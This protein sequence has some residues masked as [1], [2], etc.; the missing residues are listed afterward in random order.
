MNKGPV[1][2]LLHTSDWHLGR[3][4]YGRRRYEEFEQFLNWLV[5]TVRERAI[6]VLVVAGDV[7]DTATPS[8]RAQALYYR[9]LQQMV[10]S[11]CRHVII[12][13]GNHDSPTFLNAPADLLKAL[14]VHVIGHACEELSDQ[15]V[16]LRD[17][18]SHPQM[19]VCAVPY[20]RDRD[21]R[22]ASVGET[23]QDKEHQ[24]VDGIQQHY[25]RMAELVKT[26]RKALGVNVPVVATGHLYAAGG[27][28]V[29]GDG[30]RDL[31]IGSLGQVRAS[32]FSEVFD[33]VALGHLHVPQ[34]VGGQSRIRYSGSPIAMGFGEAG[35]QK[36]VCEVTFKPTKSA[37]SDWQLSIEAIEVPVFQRL[38]QVRGDIATIRSRLENLKR[39]GASIWV[40][41][42]YDAAEVVGDLREIIEQEVSGSSVEVLRVK[43]TGRNNT[44]L[45]PLRED[46]SLEDLTPTDVF[47]RCLEA[48]QVSEGQ[49]P[50]LRETYKEVLALLDHQPARLEAA[51]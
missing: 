48:Q 35:Q 43:L 5:Q 51:P 27:Q 4:L 21:V 28:I 16:V 46:E 38:I 47:E 29:D 10:L 6:D 34:I 36:V 31:Y 30:V 26:Q 45:T 9:F 2:K 1:L 22:V 37:A 42:L 15:L 11:S 44:A 12:V 39:D 23:T 20:L 25:H 8:N 33:Y 7:F 3:S 19:I 18:H 40:E 50:A 32:V 41:V 24:L 17:E 13:A 49:R 14:D